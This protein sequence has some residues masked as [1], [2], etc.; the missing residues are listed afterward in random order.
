MIRWLIHW[1]IATVGLMALPILIDGVTINHWQTALIAALVLGLINAFIKPVVNLLTLP[2]RILSLGLV[3]LL[4]NGAFM[5]L[6]TKIVDGF[7]IDTFF[8]AIMAAVVYSI[9]NW[10]AGVVLSIGKDK[11]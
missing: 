11:D 9:I 6:V 10:A 7:T 1:A 4:I 5:L 8:T 3:S 2:V